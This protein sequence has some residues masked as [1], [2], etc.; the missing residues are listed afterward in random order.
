MRKSPPL[1]KKKTDMKLLHAFF[2]CLVIAF[3]IAAKTPE[4]VKSPIDKRDFSFITLE[5]GLRVVV[6]SDPQAKTSAAAMVVHAGSF[7]EP[8]T[9]LGLAHYLE[10]MLFLGTKKFP[11]PDEFQNFLSRHGGTYNATT[12]N[13]KTTYFFNIQPEQMPAA[14]ERFSDFFIAP[15]FNEQLMDRELHAVDNEFHLT[16]N[17]DGQALY[18]IAKETSNP[19]HPFARFSAGNLHTLK[20]QNNLY[21]AVK[22]FYH[23]YY[24]AKNMTL[25]IVGPQSKA[26][27]IDFAKQYFGSIRSQALKKSHRPLVFQTAQLG[28]DISMRSKSLARELVIE[29]PIMVEKRQGF[30][31]PGQLISMMLGYEGPGSLAHQLKKIKWISTLAT[32]YDDISQ[33]QD[34]LA[35]HFTLTPEGIRHIDDITQMTFAYIQ[36]LKQNGISESFYDELSTMS[37]WDFHFA[38]Q[39]E[40]MELAL[41]L[42][43]RIQHYPVPNLLTSNFYLKDEALPRKE[44]AELLNQLKPHHMRRIVLAPDVETTR[45]SKWYQAAYKVKPLTAHQIKRFSYPRIKTQFAMPGKNIY[46][47][48]K[49]ALLQQITDA[50]QPP[51]KLQLGG[52]TL[53]YHQNTNYEL[54]RSNIVINI[55]FAND[56]LTP[57]NTLLADLYV[58]YASDY[59]LET[60][61]SAAVAGADVAMNAHAN[62]VAISL[63]SY[64]DKQEV[65]LKQVLQALTQLQIS[66]DDFNSLLSRRMVDLNNFRQASLFQQ[67]L[68]DLNTMLYLPAWHPDELLAASRLVTFE[69]FNQFM[70]S[71]WQAP[72]IDIL[73]H[74]NTSKRNALQFAQLLNQYFPKTHKTAPKHNAK[75]VKLAQNKTWYLPIEPSDKN[76]VLVWYL[77]NSKT[78][79]ETMAKTIL[80]A[81]LLETPYFQ[82]LRT[83]QQLGYA[84]QATPFVLDKVSGLM[85]WI[86][87]STKGSKHLLTQTRTFL[88]EYYQ[89]MA[90]LTEQDV[91]P[92]REAIVENLRQKPLTL[93]EETQRW[94]APIQRG[95]YEFDRAEKLSNA[96]E[97]VT[98]AELRDYAKECLG[99]TKGQLLVISSPPRT[100]PRQDIIPSLSALKNQGQYFEVQGT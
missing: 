42:A 60:F 31:K 9:H 23:D 87:S 18:E 55:A 75:V 34:V 2:L 49:L 63:S 96:V 6:V 29:F 28:L 74:G 7:D 54:P 89:S 16:L 90:N 88:E 27:L 21:P 72:K 3:G 95:D 76:H 68:S 73:V 40:P 82:S 66:K 45:V 10:H 32:N 57:K 48:E 25:A 84:L 37:Q 71:I 39:D 20:K 24:H 78:D 35:L 99:K 100:L 62:G 14:L 98:L 22:A 56:K 69:Q 91:A 13:E 47:P 12:Q 70:A 8:E 59:L 93:D 19:N 43:G 61:Y 46:L 15:L 30:E 97:K 77:Q 94:W 52:T 1:R 79:Y 64:S 50:E 26:K 83:E 5:N 36:F 86:Q 38:I 51:E 41:T 33:E 58:S 80:L 81:K 65:L 11:T 53:W 85:F 17:E 92:F 67:A 4:I 44:I